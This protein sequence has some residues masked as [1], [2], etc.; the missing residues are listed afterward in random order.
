MAWRCFS[1]D[2]GATSSCHLVA[3]YLTKN[4]TKTKQY[5]PVRQDENPSVECC[6]RHGGVAAG[7]HAPRL[8]HPHGVRRHPQEDCTLPQVKKAC[9]KGQ[10]HQIFDSLIFGF[11]KEP[12]SVSRDC[13]I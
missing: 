8:S 12:K 10:C 9:L 3:L 7:L 5:Y 2:L 1:L 13:L 6:D 11:K 4:I